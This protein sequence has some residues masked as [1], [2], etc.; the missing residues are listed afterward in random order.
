MA[1]HN[2]KTGDLVRI[3]VNA[4]EGSTDESDVMARDRI[5]I[6]REVLL[7]EDE[8]DGIVCWYW[9]SI[10]GHILA[11]PDST[12]LELVKPGS[13][14]REMLLD[15]VRLFYHW[16]LRQSDDWGRELINRLEAFLSIPI[17]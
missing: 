15:E 1:K 2:F 4:F 10:D 9:V 17:G 6:L 13:V 3:K 8:N 11:C 16:N 7:E 14:T 12:E 5:G